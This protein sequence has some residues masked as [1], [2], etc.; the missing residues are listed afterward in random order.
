[1]CRSSFPLESVDDIHMGIV[2]QA[3]SMEAEFLSELYAVHVYDDVYNDVYEEISE[4]VNDTN[5]DRYRIIMDESHS[6]NF[7][8]KVIDNNTE[9]ESAYSHPVRQHESFCWYG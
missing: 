8:A 3:A 2:N 5:S 9:D 7:T 1:M 4:N 6:D